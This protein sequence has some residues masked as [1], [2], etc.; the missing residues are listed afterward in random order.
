MNPPNSPVLV[1]AADTIIGLTVMRSLGRH[2]IPVYCAWSRP[3][4]LGRH[5]EY[6]R[7]AF[8]LP[9]EG[10]V[11]AILEH[12]RR[13]RV[14]HLIGI[15]E[16]H[17]SLLN[18]RRGELERE[19]TLLFPPQEIFG[20]ATN[21][22][23]TLKYARK[24]GIPIPKSVYPQSMD[25]VKQCRSL[26]FPVVLKM[27]RH[28]F[29]GKVTFQH[30]ALRVETFEDLKKVLTAL[31]AGQFP[32]VQEYISGRG[33]GMS[34]LMRGGRAVMAFQHRRVH[35]DPPDGGI[36]VLCEA[37]TPDPELFHMSEQLLSAMGWDGVAMVEYRGDWQTGRYTLMEVNGRFWGSLPTAIHAGAEFP[38][39]LYRTS[40]AA[41]TAPSPP[42]GYRAGLRARSLA[43][44]TKWLWKVLRNR[45]EPV[46]KAVMEY[47]LAFR[48]PMH[49]F[50]WAWDDP[51]PAVRNLLD[52][53]WKAK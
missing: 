32:M 34:M 4:A 45:K 44:D 26:H 21:K 41:T 49:Y 22:E 43:G 48:P 1:V 50:L 25:Q 53:F 16:N 6:C 38:F 33:I 20:R 23:L 13:W 46:L 42:V 7:G 24:A 19:F 28:D 30:K 37:L 36:G 47:L 11:E 51:Q 3:D 8:R 40:F 29:V 39:W 9:K 18:R 35:E 17:I 2:G 31:P 14:T 10:A 27:A 15:S 52:R 12:A 5:S